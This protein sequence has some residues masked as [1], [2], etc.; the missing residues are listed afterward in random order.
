MTS[1]N[2]FS[3]EVLRAD[4]LSNGRKRHQQASAGITELRR[5]KADSILQ[6]GF[7]DRRRAHTKGWTTESH[8]RDLMVTLLKRFIDKLSC[9]SSGN[10]KRA[11]KRIEV[12][13]RSINWETLQ[14]RKDKSRKVRR[15]NKTDLQSTR[16]SDD[17]T[18][19]TE[20]LR[21]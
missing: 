7:Y 5:A 2:A 3:Q 10:I 17:E 1:P 9:C 8:H 12:K 14:T 4:L 21:N 18:Q 20:S 11:H 19:M 13:S 6:R 15:K 16:C